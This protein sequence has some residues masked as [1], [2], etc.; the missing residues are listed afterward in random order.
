MDTLSR[1]WKSTQEVAAELST[2]K[3]V[4]VPVDLI[5]EKLPI[6]VLLNSPV[7]PAGVPTELAAKLPVG[8]LLE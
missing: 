8:L 3:A 1:H 6:G 2:E 7:R 5:E 4:G